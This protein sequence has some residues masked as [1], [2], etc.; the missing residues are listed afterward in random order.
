MADE[1]IEAAARAIRILGEGA[2]R[3]SAAEL[4]RLA[5][6]LAAVDVG[7]GGVPRDN[8]K[9]A[10]DALSQAGSAG[11]SEAVLA[12]LHAATMLEGTLGVEVELLRGRASLLA[13]KCGEL[14]QAAEDIGEVR[15]ATA[16]RAEQ[17]VRE[18]R[19]PAD[20]WWWM[21]FRGWLPRRPGSDNL[22]AALP[23]ND[24]VRM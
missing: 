1:V 15:R 19:R 16:V 24:Q 9:A 14:R 21:L 3:S 7:V 20:Q 10:A 22:E 11:R 17:A 13:L 18:E 4:A 5:L 23:V 6:E 12:L 2:L 8:L